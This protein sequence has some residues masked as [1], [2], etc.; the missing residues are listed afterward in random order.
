M[1]TKDNYQKIKTFRDLISWQEG[2]NLVLMIYEVTKTFPRE[3]AF[4]LTT[5]LRRAAVSCTSNI[6]EGFSRLT[7]ND[8]AHFYTMALGSLTEIQS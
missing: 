7:A 4:G 1:E 3:E 8:K 5:Q 2:H 6:A